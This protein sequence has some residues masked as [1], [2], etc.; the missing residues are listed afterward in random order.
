METSARAKA[1]VV[2]A[3]EREDSGKRALLNLGHTFGHALEA[4]A[5]YSDRLLHGEAIAIGMRQAFTYSV[6]HGLCPPED[7]ARVEKHFAAVGLPT[8]IAAIP[9]DKP[10]TCELLRLMAQDKKVKGGKLALILA[11][12]I[13]EAFVENDV[14]MDRLTEFL[15]KECA[16]R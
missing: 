11:R 16:G 4:F 8:E 13:G 2:V 7:A 1:D 14:A 5:G 15:K 3:D 12:G 6:E 9:G 10:T